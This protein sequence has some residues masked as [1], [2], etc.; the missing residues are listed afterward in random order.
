MSFNFDVVAILGKVLGVLDILVAQTDTK[1][2][3]SAVALLHAAY[4]DE[5]I[6]DWLGGL[7]NHDPAAFQ[8]APMPEN[9][10]LALGA[11]GIDWTKIFSNLPAI[12]AII[13]A[14]A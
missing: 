3:D 8:S 2:D 12:I 14:L 13:K 9:V 4:D 6:R 10:K 1:V 11:R 7:L 5:T